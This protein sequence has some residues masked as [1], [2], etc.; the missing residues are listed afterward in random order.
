[1]SSTVEIENGNVDILCKS[2]NNDESYPLEESVTN[3]K[4]S[5]T[6]RPLEE[7]DRSQIKQLHE[8]LFPVAYT[9]HFYNTVVKNLTMDGKPLFS[10]IA[11]ARGEDEENSFD[12]TV[13]YDAWERF[14]NYEG[15]EKMNVGGLYDRWEMNEIISA[16]NVSSSC[17]QVLLQGDTIAACVVGT[18]VDANKL[19]DETLEQLVRNPERHSLMFYIMTLGSNENFRG[20]GLGSKLIRECINIAEQVHTCGVIY[21]HVITYNTTAIRFYENL[22]FHRITEIKDYYMIDDKTYDCYLYARCANG[23]LTIFG[24]CFI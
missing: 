8:K 4:Y 21:L 22:G 7:E 16:G 19:D 9:D 5:I 18:F 13:H 10:C 12:S 6:F 11:I 15:I 17:R 2:Q 23:K 24:M 20:R 1:M 3:I 14:A